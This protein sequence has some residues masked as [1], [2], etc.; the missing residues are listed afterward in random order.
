MKGGKQ[1]SDSE[2]SDSRTHRNRLQ[3]SENGLYNGYD[4]NA[5]PK[6]ADRAPYDHVVSESDSSDD[7]NANTIGNVPLEWYR[8]EDHIGYDR[9]GSAILK[10]RL[11]FLAQAPVTRRV[12]AISN[13]KPHS[14]QAFTF[15]AEGICERH[16]RPSY[17]TIRGRKI[18]ANSI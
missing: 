12:Y 11:V 3:E 10:V 16:P 8:H 2:R 4:S 18:M 6:L 13:S 5:A 15:F 14:Y 1:G 17:W 7:E 9:E